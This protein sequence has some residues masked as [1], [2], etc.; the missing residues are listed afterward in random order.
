MKKLTKVNVAIT[1]G[2]LYKHKTAGL[3]TL[4]NIGMI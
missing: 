4:K 3:I 1:P 2:K